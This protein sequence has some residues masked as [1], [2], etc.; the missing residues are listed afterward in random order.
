MSAEADTL[1]T[2]DEAAAEQAVEPPPPEPEASKSP[3]HSLDK[4]VPRMASPQASVSKRPT[5][6]AISARE[7][8]L[9]DQL[10]S[11]R[12]RHDM[13]LRLESKARE[14]LEDMLLRLEKQYKMEQAARAKA[15]ELM[16]N[17]IMAE[18]ETAAKLE[19]ATKAKDQGLEAEKQAVK[20]VPKP[21]SG[22]ASSCF[23]GASKGAAAGTCS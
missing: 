11:E 2:G 17:A 5:G 15:E 10:V 22:W 3:T 21:G 20:K 7:Q 16:N 19:D 14:E 9:T 6:A 1:Q 13:Q 18:M 4:V 23:A 12:E 8:E